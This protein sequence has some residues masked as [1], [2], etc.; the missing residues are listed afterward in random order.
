[1]LPSARDVRTVVAFAT[2]VL[3]MWVSLGRML[4][5]MPALDMAECAAMSPPASAEPGYL[6]WLVGMWTIMMAAMM[7]PSAAPMTFAF[8]RFASP[9]RRRARPGLLTTAFVGGY[10]LVWV[11]FALAA[12]SAQWGLEHTAVMSSAAMAVRSEVLAGM[13]LMVAGL[14]QWTSVKHSCLRRCRTPIGFLMTEWR[15]G[16]AGALRMGWR[17]GVFCV[18]CCWALMLLLLVTGVMNALWIVLLAIIVAIEKIVPFG[19]GV[20]RLTGA[21]LLGWGI[22]L[23]AT[24]SSV[25]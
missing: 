1:M 6:A 25:S 2:L 17:Y 15:S 11:V 24:G 16:T 20:A 22:W 3:V 14:Y 12:A 23:I 7:L 18:G 8:A 19:N 13:L 10:L 21:C 4:W 9:D 5:G